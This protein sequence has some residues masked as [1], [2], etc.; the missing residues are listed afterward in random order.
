MPPRLQVA[1]A[2]IGLASSVL[3]RAPCVVADLRAGVEL[4]N[5]E[6][7]SSKQQDDI[8]LKTHVAS[9]CFRCFRDMLQVFYIDVAKLNQNVTHV[10]MTIHICL[11]C[12][13]QCFIY[14]RR[15]LQVFH[16]DIAKLNQDFAY[17]CMCLMCFHTYVACVS[18]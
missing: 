15:M 10:T 2:T 9:V 7:H 1:R 4:R 13:F 11:K 8:P 12:M 18:S 17:I 3:P 5:D 14:F 16:L 6:P